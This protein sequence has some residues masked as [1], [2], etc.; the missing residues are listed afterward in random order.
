MKIFINGISARQ[1][2]GVTYLNAFLEYFLKK[3]NVYIEVW[4]FSNINEGL[5][6]YNN[7]KVVPVEF[8]MINMIG[9]YYIERFVITSYLKNNNFDICFFPNGAITS[10]VPEQSV[11]VTMFRNMLPFNKLFFKYYGLSFRSL[12]LFILKQRFLSSYRKA[13]S[14]I[15]I[16]EYARNVIE[17][18][19]PNIVNK[20]IV[21]PHGISNKFRIPR[22]KKSDISFVYISIYTNY[23]H[24]KEIVEGAKIFRS[25]H[26]YAPKIR[27]FGY[28]LGN[29]KNELKSLV[30][31][32]DLEDYIQIND[33]LAHDQVP[34]VYSESSY[35]I[36]ASSCENCPNLLL[37]AMATGVPIL[38]S[39]VMP[40]P[41]FLGNKGIYFDPFNP[42]SISKSFEKV[43]LKN[44]D[45]E[46]YSRYLLKKS[47]SYSWSRTFE[48]TYGYFEQ[49]IRN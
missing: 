31:K 38:C 32:Y 33:S 6:E 37:E 7:L 5:L 34:N 42:I 12:R 18:I 2:G 8:G 23:K 29:Y 30:Q 28:K 21:I 43:L 14:I 4:G 47:N 35:A 48:K 9:R 45:A 1:G 41:E 13:D 20:S 15:F 19:I 10:N 17:E 49:A 3:K 25:E 26:G 11:S 27:M 44:I 22:V 39:N 24:Q 40:M 36:F 46:N 16:S